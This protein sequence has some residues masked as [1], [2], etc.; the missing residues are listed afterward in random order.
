MWHESGHV[1]EWKLGLVEESAAFREDRA[2]E[3]PENRKEKPNLSTIT[4]TKSADEYAV[5]DFYHFYIGTRIKM[6]RFSSK[7]GATEVLSSGIE[8]LSSS[9]LAKRGI[10]RDRETML[11]ALSAMD[12]KIEDK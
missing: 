6:D 5:G 9:V 2:E 7:D 3:T 11:Y 10:K 4:E 1:L 8:L 12:K